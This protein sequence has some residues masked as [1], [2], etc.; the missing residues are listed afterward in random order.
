MEHHPTPGDALCGALCPDVSHRTVS[1][2]LGVP[3][4]P[5]CGNEILYVPRN[6]AR[7]ASDNDGGC[8]PGESFDE[9]VLSISTCV[10][11]TH[12]PALLSAPYNAP[13]ILERSW[14]GR[15]NSVITS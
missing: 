7:A 9:A 4:A 10:R 1:F 3:F 2:R 14:E 12:A 6:D 13:I 15:N 8:T 5:V 11:L